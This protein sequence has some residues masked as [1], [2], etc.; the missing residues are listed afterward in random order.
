MGLRLQVG[1]ATNQT[2][3]DLTAQLGQLRGKM[4]ALEED[5]EKEFEQR[6][7]LRVKELTQSH[8]DEARQIRLECLDR[9]KSAVKKVRD[10]MEAALQAE[11]DAS[12]QFLQQLGVDEDERV[13]KKVKEAKRE[14][15]AHREIVEGE[16]H[17]ANQRVGELEQMLAG[18]EQADLTKAKEQ[19]RRERARNRKIEKQLQSA[20]AE[21]DVLKKQ[22]QNRVQQQFQGSLENLTQESPEVQK[23]HKMVEMYKSEARSLRAQIDARKPE[24]LVEL[25]DELKGRDGE[26][27]KLRDEIKTLKVMMARQERELKANKDLETEYN[28]KVELLLGDI[29]VRCPKTTLSLCQLWQCGW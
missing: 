19:V 20:E 6:L 11:R 25:Q 18:S 5:K 12:E 21:V 3:E 9:E 23:L 26:E 7:S 15:L 24:K 17:A 2:V 22:H 29:Q 10:D 1:D 28:K 16:L 27:G 4:R 14:W 13:R 8:L